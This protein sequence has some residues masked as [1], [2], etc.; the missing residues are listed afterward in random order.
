MD[1]VNA[2]LQPLLRPYIVEAHKVI[3]KQHGL[4]PE[5]TPP[6]SKAPLT[7]EAVTAPAPSKPADVA[8][9]GHLALFNQHMTQKKAP[10][11]WVFETHTGAPGV[12]DALLA[13]GEGSYATPVWVV[14]AIMGEKGAIGAGKGRTKK[15]AMNEAAKAALATLGVQVWEMTN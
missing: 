2:W 3:R 13:E 14:R 12:T 5:A 10:I 1:A 8:P 15:A 4:G 7:D 11:E 6:P 9:M